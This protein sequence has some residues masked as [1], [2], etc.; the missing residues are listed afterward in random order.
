MKR[1][2]II[3][4]AVG[5][6]VSVVVVAF[7]IVVAV[8]PRATEP[9][10]AD[11][12]GMTQPRPG[13]EW[14]TAIFGGLKPADSEPTVVILDRQEY[15]LSGDF[16]VHR[17]MMRRSVPRFWL[18]LV[19]LDVPDVHGVGWDYLIGRPAWY[20]VSSSSGA[21]SQVILSEEPE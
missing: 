11:L 16:I 15:P 5:A 6:V 7:L 21:V 1:P 12:T 19:L 13:Y 2:R 18:H 8:L 3:K 9:T 17:A 4:L 20:E 10:A 14:R